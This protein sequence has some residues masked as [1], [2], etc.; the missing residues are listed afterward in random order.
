[1][2]PLHDVRAVCFDWG[3]TL[4]S[5]DGPPDVPMALWP[6]VQALDGAADAL[7]LLA[8]RLP[9]AIATNAAVSDRPM[10]ER[11][12]S[13][14][15][16]GRCIDQVFCFTELGCRKDQPA[17]WAAVAATLGCPAGRIA[18]VGDS[19]EQDARGPRA[20]GVQGVWLR[21]GAAAPVEAGVPCVADLRRFAQWVL[22]ARAPR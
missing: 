5:E 14:V 10:I 8:G 11:A 16:L 1:M 22:A 2:N 4:M 19:L 15:G 6:H 13:R 7:R 17:F 21:P 9:L 12:L 20:C 3:G 18:M